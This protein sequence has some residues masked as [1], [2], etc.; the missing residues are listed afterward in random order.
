[1]KKV[2]C[3]LLAA[4]MVF[5]LAA[6]G[7][8][9]VDV[10]NIDTTTVQEAP[11]T[12]TTTP[13][14]TTT[15]TN[16]TTTEEKTKIFYT[17][18]SGDVDTLNGQASVSEANDTPLSWCSAYLWRA[19]PNEDGSG[20]VYV[21][22]LA[23]EMPIQIDDLT[24]Q[25]KLRE[26]ACWHN[27]EKITADDW[28]FTFQT[29]I[30]PVAV[31]PMAGFLADNN[32]TIKN[33]TE[34]M[35]QGES[36][37][38]SWDEVGIKKIDDYTI[39]V[40]TETPVNETDF[41]THFAMRTNTPLYKPLYEEN[42]TSD[43]LT[44]SYGTTLE[45]WMGCGPY[46]F[47]TWTY[48]SIQ[49]YKKNPDYWLAD[50]FKFDE[51]QVRIVP[52]AN[53]LVELFESGQLDSFTP[54]VSSMVTYIDDPRLVSYP[55]VMVYHYDVN[56]WNPDNPLAQSINYRT[57]LYLAMNRYV[58]AKD[59][60][61]YKEPAAT[62]VNGM[63]GILHPDSKGVP[64]RQT[65]WGT[66]V[67]DYIEEKFGDRYAFNPELAKEYMQKAYEECGLDWDKD[68]ITLTFLEGGYGEERKMNELF[69]E[70]FPQ[71]FDGRIQI[72]TLVVTD[73]LDHMW[74]NLDQWDL[75]FMDWGRSLS[76]T[77]PYQC[78]YYF[79]EDYSS[80][81]NNM[82]TPEFQAQWEACEAVKT[83]SYAE[84]CEETNKLEHVQLDEIT[85]I[86]L[87]QEVNYVLFNE[88]LDLPCGNYIPGFGWGT[89]F[90]DKRVD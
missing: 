51:V 41:C 26:E 80:H 64:Y 77:L 90:A 55:S 63:A 46:Y 34:Y 10:A 23:G 7:K 21:P 52:E 12:T 85:V 11:Q 28:M 67:Y 74:N 75:A 66:E 9:T 68:V 20:F 43:G 83:G 37:T 40:T 39:E 16:D 2:I 6:C 53:A 3:L 59:I 78:M 14:Q 32:I 72:E 58:I 48:D 44:S 81:P 87:Y 79:L 27:G 1:M 65:E 88:A 13:T 22:D 33:A 4:M 42:L 60:W 86:P 47:D 84:I 57:A 54:D 49:I 89:M 30:D 69:M 56:F 18:L 19:V 45:A 73:Y 62:Y 5:S 35:L 38:V 61:G 25:I 17:Y 36:K 29:C 82:F 70:E 71:I 50:L 8:Q 31:Q 15:T 76:R 24:W